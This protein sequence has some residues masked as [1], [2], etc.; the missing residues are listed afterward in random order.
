MSQMQYETTIVID[1]LQKS[2]DM[3][4]MVAKIE[5]FIKN[6]GGTI[7]E[8]EEWGKKRLAYE[9]NRKQYGTYYHILFEGPSTIPA[10]LEAEYRLQ[11]SILRYLTVKSDPRVLKRREKKAQE[12]AEPVPQEKPVEEKPVVA[13]APL[14]TTEAV[15][16]PDVE[17]ADAAIDESETAEE[18]PAQE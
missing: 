18:K 8:I 7:T 6:N 12:N 14:E 17:E 1:S 9:I 11:E 15:V 2:E 5:N 16:E 4:N 10:L 13:A 3:Q